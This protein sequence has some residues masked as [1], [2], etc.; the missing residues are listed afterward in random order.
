MRLP[1]GGDLLEHRRA[2]VGDITV[3]LVVETALEDVVIGVLGEAGILG[4]LLEPLDGRVEVTGGI[5]DVSYRIAGRGG[6]VGEGHLLHGE[7]ALAGAGIVQQRIVAVGA[8]EHV[9][10][11]LLA[12]GFVTAHIASA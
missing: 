9:L 4:G 10:G 1:L 11:H 12:V 6:I 5:V 2:V 8:L 3:V 7:E